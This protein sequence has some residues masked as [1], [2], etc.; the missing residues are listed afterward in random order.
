MRSTAPTSSW[1]GSPLAIVLL[2]ALVA[3]LVSVVTV[4][5]AVPQPA[6]VAG[7]AAASDEALLRE[8]ADLRREL[9]QLRFAVQLS[10]ATNPNPGALPP[11]GGLPDPAP[12]PP[13]TPRVAAA[14]SDR[15]PDP[16]R[17]Y[18]RFDVPTSA[19]TVRQGSGGDLVIWS[20]DPALAGQVI[21]VR[22]WTS[23]ATPH[24]LRLT[25]PPVEGR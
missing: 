18:E 12:E 15:P 17:R 11:P 23:D 9:T 25:V 19:V 10:A 16:A 5:L 1:R 13:P 21:E 2:A 7:S 6:V 24:L 20:T 8:V 14:P 3:A 22:A 4:R